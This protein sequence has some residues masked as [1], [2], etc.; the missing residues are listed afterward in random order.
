MRTAAVLMRSRQR[1]VASCS[2]VGRT[3]DL[4]EMVEKEPVRLPA[5]ELQIP[6]PF[7][8]ARFAEHLGDHTHARAGFR[9]AIERG[10]LV[11]AELEARDIGQLDLG[12]ALELLE[13]SAALR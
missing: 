8:P 2:Q 3:R 4:P 5:P 7:E 9:R 6:P 1:R 12:E 10:N 11:V 13:S